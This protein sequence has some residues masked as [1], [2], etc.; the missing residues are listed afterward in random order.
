MYREPHAT[1]PAALPALPTIDCAAEAGRIEA[2]LVHAAARRLNRRGLVLGVSG[3]VD[4]AVCATL[5]ARSVGPERVFALLM[6]ERHSPEDATQRA[7]SLCE[8]LGIRYEIE[9]ITESLAAIGCYR[10]STEAIRRMF[11]RFAEDWRHKITISGTEDGQ[12]PH[13]DLVVEDPEGQRASRRMPAE[14]YLQLVAATNFKQR[15][16]KNLEYY[17]AERLNYAVL[18]TPN[19][20]EYR[21]GFFV[22]GGDGLADVKP[23]AHLYKSQVYALATWLG[24]PEEIRRQPP[25]TDTYSLPQTQEEFYFALS[26]ERADLALHAMSQGLSPAATA[27]ALG[28]TTTQVEGIFRDF[29]GKHRVAERNLGQAIVLDEAA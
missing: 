15:L 16:R 9:D 12:L 26:Y 14:V 27:R 1:D 8:S 29:E 13:F 2:F 19:R 20:L 25:S 4:S 10:R 17:H 5:A 22:R 23:I 24:V 21:L 11:P 6:P 7:R 28:L 3:G 18:G